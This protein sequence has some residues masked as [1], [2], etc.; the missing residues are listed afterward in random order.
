MAM[1]LVLVTGALVAVVVALRLVRAGQPIMAPSPA[2]VGLLAG[3]PKNALVAT[4]VTMR[5]RGEIGIDRAGVLR[6]AGEL[7]DTTDP[8]ERAV[9]RVLSLPRGPKEI[10]AHRTSITA[11]GVLR[12]RLVAAGLL[13]SAPRWAASRILPVAAVVYCL[14]RLA[15]GANG[16]VVGACAALAVAT[17]FLPRRTL[18]GSRLLAG[19]RREFP[20]TGEPV[21]DAERIG[22]IVAVHRRVDL[23]G[24]EKFARRGGLSDGGGSNSRGVEDPHVDNPSMPI[25]SLLD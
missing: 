4:L 5:R 8:V 12:R 6:S 16:L 1:D 9:Y 15:G 19:L 20:V 22:M 18:A 14:V 23:P 13:L 21:P 25:T 24:L 2:L 17:L 11:F 7:A 10:R 3:G